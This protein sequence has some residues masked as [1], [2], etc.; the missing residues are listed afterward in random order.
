M[1]GMPEDLERRLPRK[2]T[3]VPPAPKGPLLEAKAGEDEMTVDSGDD[4][5][6]GDR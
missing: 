5:D 6:D 4:T 3:P 2:S 1:V